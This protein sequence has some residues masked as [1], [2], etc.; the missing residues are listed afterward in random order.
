MGSQ[1]LEQVSPI[2]KQRTKVSRLPPWC[3]YI[4]PS[5]PQ[6]QVFVD[7]DAVEA[8]EAGDEPTASDPIFDEANQED[9]GE[10][11]LPDAEETSEEGN[12]EAE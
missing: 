8:E 6:V 5:E 7:G 9:T 4:E 2:K 3:D 10:Q 1:G 12:I 11:V